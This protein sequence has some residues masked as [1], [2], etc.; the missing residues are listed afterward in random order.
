MSVLSVVFVNWLQVC[1]SLFLYGLETPPRSR[2][3]RPTSKTT[4]F[5][6]QWNRHHTHKCGEKA[7]STVSKLPPATQPAARDLLI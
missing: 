1:S 3:N 6:L 7:Q 2:Q 4:F 5:A